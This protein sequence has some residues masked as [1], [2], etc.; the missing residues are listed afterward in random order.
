MS[1]FYTCKTE[2]CLAWFIRLRSIDDK[3]VFAMPSAIHTRCVHVIYAARLAI[4]VE[5]ITKDVGND[6]AKAALLEMV[7]YPSNQPF[8]N[9][10]HISSIA[11]T[12]QKWE[13]GHSNVSE[14]SWLDDNHFTAHFPNSN[15][16]ISLA[17]IGLAVQALITNTVSCLPISPTAPNGL[18]CP[19]SPPC[20]ICGTASSLLPT[21]MVNF[22]L[23]LHE[24][25]SLK[26]PAKS[27]TTSFVL[28]TSTRAL[29]PVDLRQPH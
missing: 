8:A 21:P 25:N 24:H 4:A 9:V 5:A 28:S 13:E 29:L 15:I 27:S 16:T 14:F 10:V 20:P 11:S 18:S 19:S 2:S 22:K 1:S 17:S 12:Y 23:K 7:K 26:S 6:D 3:G